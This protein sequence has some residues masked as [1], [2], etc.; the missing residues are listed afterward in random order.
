MP[1]QLDGYLRNWKTNNTYIKRILLDTLNPDT[2]YQDR[3]TRS[4]TRS[5][6]CGFSTHMKMHLRTFFN[7]FIVTA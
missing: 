4:S 7:L 1:C 3:Y 2:S 5:P 6:T